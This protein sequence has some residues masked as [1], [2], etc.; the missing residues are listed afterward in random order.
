LVSPISHRRHEKIKT[1]KWTYMFR[2]LNRGFA[3]LAAILSILAPDA[4]ALCQVP[5]PRLVCAEYANS[6]AV[7]IAKL[8][9]IRELVRDGE[10]DG[11][12]YTLT[13]RSRLRGHIGPT[14]PYIS[15][16]GRE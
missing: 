2:L 9:S 13:V 10:T 15:G 6:Q 16:V 7:V 4:W 5:Q 12:F 8:L 3:G 1:G 11:Y 14:R